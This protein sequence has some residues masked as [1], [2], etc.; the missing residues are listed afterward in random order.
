MVCM[1]NGLNIFDKGEVFFNIEKRAIYLIKTGTFETM[2]EFC[3][4]VGFKTLY[5]FSKLM[6]ERFG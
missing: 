3:Y 5:Y 2:K 1:N 4:A 6:K